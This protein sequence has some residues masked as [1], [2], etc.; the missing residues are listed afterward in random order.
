M[1]LPQVLVQGVGGRTGVYL[2]QRPA[3]APTVTVRDSQ[4]TDQGT[5]TD[6]A[7]ALQGTPTALN[8]TGGATARDT[9]LTLDDRTDLVPGQDYE[10]GMLDPEAADTVPYEQPET[11]RVL[12]YTAT[13]NQIQTTR[14]LLY[15]HG[16]NSPVYSTLAIVNAFGEVAATTGALVVGK[17]YTLTTFVAGDDFTNVGAA[18]NE[19]GVSFTATGTAP[20]TWTNGS[21]VTQVT[22]VSGTWRHGR[23]IFTWTDRAGIVQNTIVRVDAI[24]AQ[25]DAYGQRQY[26]HAIPTEQCVY[27]RNPYWSTTM[28]HGVDMRSMLRLAQQEV[29]ARLEATGTQARTM[30]GVDQVTDA[31]AYYVLRE[32][33]KLNAETDSEVNPYEAKFHASYRQM[34]A[35]AAVDENQDGVIQSY[36]STR[37]G[38]F[39]IVRGG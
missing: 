39:K 23:A 17:R 7:T 10:I 29:L 2:P 21:T 4:N 28:G 12:R 19:S 30:V 13:A 37:P 27:D 14:P 3:A 20:T 1:I 5:L 33:W 9:F 32:M 15:D 22:D 6:A 16:D 35:T 38:S 18:S 24:A 31:A 25:F 36:E 34:V 8:Q 26:P 11:F